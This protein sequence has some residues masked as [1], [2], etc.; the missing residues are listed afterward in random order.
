MFD[1]RET[2]IIAVAELGTDMRR[3]YE[4][5]RAEI[6]SHES[7]SAGIRKFQEAEAAVNQLERA[8]SNL[9]SRS[10]ALLVK[11]RQ[12]SSALESALI[13]AAK[14]GD[15]VDTSALVQDEVL[16]RGAYNST[17]SAYGEVLEKLLPAARF[18]MRHAFMDACLVEAAELEALAHERTQ[19]AIDLMGAVLE[20]EGAVRI[21]TRSSISGCLIQDASWLRR[22]AEQERLNL[23]R[24][25]AAHME[26]ITRAERA[27]M[28]AQVD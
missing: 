20:L 15:D 24:D 3:K 13:Q 23:H 7:V 16:A 6:R 10:S 25:E 17:V 14:N 21:D 18:A 27:R 4:Q 1:L 5:L 19:R 2:P 12:V 28:H 26:R 9:Q 8:S 11:L 22:E